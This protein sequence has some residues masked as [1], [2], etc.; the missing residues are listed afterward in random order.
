MNFIRLDSEKQK[1]NK[2]NTVIIILN[3]ETCIL[4]KMNILFNVYFCLG[5]YSVN[6][7]ILK[8]VFWMKMIAILSQMSVKHY[9]IYQPLYSGRIWHKVN[10]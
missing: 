6:S 9:H 3:S 4:K 5:K 7:I 1:Q 2:K 8:H 10:F